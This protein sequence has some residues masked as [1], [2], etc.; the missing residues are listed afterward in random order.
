YLFGRK[1]V[2]VPAQRRSVSSLKSQ[3]SSSAPEK[4]KGGRK[5]QPE[6]S[7]LKSGTLSI[8][9]AR[10]NNLKKLDVD[11]PLGVFCCITGVS[12]SG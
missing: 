4:V 11:I 10:Q 3:V 7:N 5:G 1:S 6:T 8:H 9:G 2:P 12:G